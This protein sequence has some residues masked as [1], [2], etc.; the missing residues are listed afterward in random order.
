M[1]TGANS[2]YGSD[3]YQE[4]AYSIEAHTTHERD[5][6]DEGAATEDSDSNSSSTWL[7]IYDG[8]SPLDLAEQ[9]EPVDTSLE[10][11][12]SILRPSGTAEST[13]RF[14]QWSIA[15][16]APGQVP[17]PDASTPVLSLESPVLGNVGI[18][19]GCFEL[20]M[21]HCNRAQELERELD[22]LRWE[23]RD[24]NA[25]LL[26]RGDDIAYYKKEIESLREARHD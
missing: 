13:G 5:E 16:A 23:R 24:L 26:C 8:D 14:L 10:H 1:N 2:S 11:F 3:D 22:K 7:S 6:I 17:F 15:D 12:N 19:K 9:P 18:N 20:I 4:E 25:E 21:L